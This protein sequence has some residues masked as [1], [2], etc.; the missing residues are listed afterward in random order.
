MFIVDIVCT[1]TLHCNMQSMNMNNILIFVIAVAISYL[2]S[3]N[4]NTKYCIVVSI[5]VLCAKSLGEKEIRSQVDFLAL[6]C[7]FH[8]DSIKTQNDTEG[9]L[10]SLF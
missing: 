6:L 3:S 8:Y 9:Q 10:L 1:F 2:H 7:P 5:V 4:R